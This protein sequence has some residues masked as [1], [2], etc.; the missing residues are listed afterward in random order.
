MSFWLKRPSAIISDGVAL[1]LLFHKIPKPETIFNS[2]SRTKS[3][4]YQD[5]KLYPVG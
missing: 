4:Y 1:E 5:A 3:N 2:S